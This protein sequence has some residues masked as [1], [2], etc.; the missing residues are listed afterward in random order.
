MFKSLKHL[1][2]LILS[3]AILQT[4]NAQNS[5]P[6]QE[7]KVS[8]DGKHLAVVLLTE[9]KRSLAFINLESMQYVGATKLPRLSEVGDFYWANNER[10]LV[11]VLKKEAW[12]KESIYYGEIFA[13]NIDGT[14]AEMIYGYRAIYDRKARGAGSKFKKKEPTEGSAEI[15]N[16]L[17]N[18]DRTILISSTLWPTGIKPS[19]TRWVDHGERSA[20]LHRLDIYN[21]QFENK[22]I[23]GA[24]VSYASILSDSSGE[25]KVAYGRDAKQQF[26]VLTE[27]NWQQINADTFGDKFTPLIID[28][29]GENLLALDNLNQSTTSLFSYNLASGEYSKIT[30]NSPDDVKKALISNDGHSIYAL[31]ANSPE[32]NYVVH[33]L[34]SAEAQVFSGL[35]NVFKNQQLEIASKSQDDTI[36]IVKVGQ[37]ATNQENAGLKFYLYNRATNKLVPLS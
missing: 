37:Q 16:L 17:A 28:K 26:Y 19:D 12:R 24:P 8:P 14:K 5:S 34:D 4:A 9:G 7:V 13:T 3:L 21:G 2:V 10:I 22:R 20:S 11:K 33:Q 1:A 29:S 32:V 35:L 30:D 27:D 23:A 31:L 36:F 15:I 18:D 25:V 6:F